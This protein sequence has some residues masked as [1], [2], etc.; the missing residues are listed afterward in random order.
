MCCCGLNVEAWYAFNKQKRIVA[1]RLEPGYMPDGWLGDICGNNR[2][3]DFSASDKFDEEWSKLH[4]KLKELNRS[5]SYSVI[6]RHRNREGNGGARPAMLKQWGDSTVFRHGDS[7]H[8]KHK[9]QKTRK[10]Y[11]QL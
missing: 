9:H 11:I 4:A 7:K 10:S 3:Y 6:Q 2:F 1:L 5:G 8:K